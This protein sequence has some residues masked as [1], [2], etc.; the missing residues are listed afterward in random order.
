M[1]KDQFGVMTLVLNLLACVIYTLVS[2]SNTYYCKWIYGNDNLVALLGTI[3]MIP[4]ILGFVL[5][6]LMIKKFGV[7]KTLKISFLIGVAANALRIFN[8]YDIVF[9]ALCSSAGTFDNI[10]MMCLLD[11][12]TTMTIDYNECRYGVKMVA[13]SNSASS[14]GTKIAGGLGSALIGWHL[15]LANYDVTLEVAATATQ[16]VIYTFYIYITLA[17][18]AVMFPDKLQILPGG[19]AATEQRGN[20]DEKYKGRITGVWSKQ[21]Q[22]IYTEREASQGGSF[23]HLKLP[24]IKSSG[25]QTRRLKGKEN[26]NM[27]RE[28]ILKRLKTF[29]PELKKKR[30]IVSSDVKNEADDPFAVMHHLLTPSEEIVGIISCH[31]EGFG[32]MMQQIL[33][34]PIKDQLDQKS[35]Q[36]IENIVGMRGKTE[37]HSYEEGKKILK[38]A[39]IEDVPLIHGSRCELQN[40]E[41]L[42]DSPGADFIIR[43]AMR[44]DERPLYIAMQGAVTDLAIAYLKEP[45]IGERLTL[46]WIG[47]GAYPAGG[48][49]FNLKQDILAANTV[50]ESAIPVWQIPI[51]VY[52]KVEVSIPE[53][54]ANV[55]H[56]GAIGQYLCD[57]MQE[58]NRQSEW[59]GGSSPFPHGESWCLGDNPTVTALL[60]GAGRV[61]WKECRAPHINADY[62]YEHLETGKMIR[63]YDDIDSRLTLSDFFAKMQLCYGGKK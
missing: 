15:A 27:K 34:S 57:Q 23:L 54:V 26:R 5:V 39:E 11:V 24:V 31:Y 61:T 3:G 37:N 41:N 44:E 60:Q 20:Q 13:S 19:E 25:F 46:I 6:G 56:C 21:N 55:S 47:G 30:V 48:D 2:G 49:E 36:R 10:P 51:N 22:I 12:L 29:V 16:Y 45:A 42:P 40:I 8:P 32:M 58:Y 35:L 33:D 28:E 50:F 9:N 52:S 1:G 43:E 7:V 18:F 63:V 38:L 14:F 4:T 62:S 17:I 53:L 59:M